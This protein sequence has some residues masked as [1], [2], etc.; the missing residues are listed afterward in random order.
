LREKDLQGLTLDAAPRRRRQV[1]R[2][3]VHIGLDRI[4]VLL[5]ELLDGIAHYLVWLEGA[6]PLVHHTVG[7]QQGPAGIIAAPRGH[8][9]GGS[10]DNH[11]A[12]KRGFL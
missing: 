10:R 3:L 12:L 6:H 11:F 8:I 2:Y 4:E 9:G 5:A 7:V 1:L